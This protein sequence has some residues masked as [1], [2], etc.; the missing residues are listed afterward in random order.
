MLRFTK[1][2]P[3]SARVAFICK[4][5][6]YKA[7]QAAKDALK[8]LNDY[9]NANT[10]EPMY[11]LHAMW[12][13]QQNA[14]TYKE[15]RDAIMQGYM[16]ETILQAWQQ[17]YAKFV[18]NRLVPIW[19]ET[20]K[21]GAAAIQAQA[22]GGWAFDPMGLG[23]SRWIASHGAR[24][25][26]VIT[27]ETRSAMQ[28]MIDASVSGQFTIDELSRAIR[29]LIG[30]NRPQAE[31]NLKYYESV[32]ANLLKNN[33]NMRE[34]TAEKRAREAALKYEARQLRQRAQMIA[35]TELSAAYCAGYREFVRQSQ[36]AGLIG[37]GVFVWDTAA[38]EAVCVI[39]GALNGMKSNAEGQYSIG[40][41]RQK[42][43]YGDSPPAHPRCRCA[44]HFEETEPPAVQTDNADQFRAMPR[45][46]QAAVLG[47][48]DGGRQ[49]AALLNSRVIA[50]D[51]DVEDLY[52]A[53]VVVSGDRRAGTISVD[54]EVTLKSLTELA[55]H[56]IVT[57]SDEAVA[58]SSIGEYNSAGRII[59]GCHSQAGMDELVRRG[60]E[61]AIVRA[62]TNGVR[63]GNIPGHKEKF[64]RAGE[65]Q[66]WFPPDW[67]DDKIMEAGTAVA[68]SDA[69]LQMGYY[70]VGEYEGVM[71]RVLFATDGSGKIISVCPDYNQEVL[72]GVDYFE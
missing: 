46:E 12:T 23:M 57:V 30:L 26:T 3:T 47:G 10:A 39:C 62:F 36:T 35:E 59:G 61:F 14:I 13:N 56:G 72:E 64:K 33:P 54:V 41:Q 43:K 15:L 1:A 37:K 32:K 58:H 17:D 27:E 24:W 44:E 50:N 2:A 6:K 53:K 9:L 52:H 34:V 8:K 25:V 66:A 4:A 55:E 18:V 29:P 21:A 63:L 68:N 31:A 49:R 45:A 48:K 67:D 16:D 20:A 65:K 7:S 70:K 69:P 11:F 51:K 42:F 22:T 38:D 60:I 40:P 28:A 19:R 5:G 71:V